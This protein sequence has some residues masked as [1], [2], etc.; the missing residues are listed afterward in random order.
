[1]TY[2]QP[3]TVDRYLFVQVL[4]TTAPFI[5]HR[6]IDTSE[7]EFTY[8]RSFKN[9][10]PEY[11]DNR[12]FA[13]DLQAEA[14]V[15]GALQTPHVPRFCEYGTA[16]DHEFLT[17]K[18]IWGKSLLQILRELKKHQKMLSDVYACHIANEVCRCLSHA[19]SL[20]TREFPEGIVHYN[21]SPRNIIISYSGRVHVVNFG[22]KGPMLTRENL[23]EFDFRNLSYL[24]PEQISRQ[25]LSHKSDL[26][27]VGALLYEMLTGA[28]PFLERTADKIVARIAKCSFL[29]ASQVNDIS[30]P[31]L[32]EFLASALTPY[33]SDRFAS[34]GLMSESLTSYLVRKHPDF[35]EIKLMLLMKALFNNEIV[36]DIKQIHWL[37]E[38]VEPR[39]RLLVKS[40]P[41]IMYDTISEERRNAGFDEDGLSMGSFR[42]T[43][44]IRPRDVS[45]AL[46]G[47][48]ANVDAPGTTRQ[49]SPAQQVPPARQASLARQAPPARQVELPDD[50]FGEEFV[51]VSYTMEEFA[52]TRFCAPPRKESFFDVEDTVLVGRSWVDKIPGEKERRALLDSGEFV[53]EFDEPPAAPAT[54]AAPTPAVSMTPAPAPLPEPVRRTRHLDLRSAMDIPPA[55]R[56][57]VERKLAQHPPKLMPTA[58]PPAPAPPA[59]APVVTAPT[60]P[61]A[62]P[63]SDPTRIRFSDGRKYDALAILNESDHRNQLIGRVLGEYTITGILGWGGMGTVYDGIQPTI[64]KE[65][66]IKVLNPQLCHDEK[67]T[68][69]FLAEAKAVNSIRNP[70]IIDIFAFGVLEGRFHYFVMEKLNG[71]PLSGYLQRHGTAPVGE[72]YEIMLQV[73]N[74]VQAAHEKGIIHRDLKPDNIFLENRALFR[75]YVKILDFGIAKFL[76]AKMN[77]GGSHIGAPI[78]TPEYMSPEHC[79]NDGV[80]AA[81]DIYSLGVI[82]FE[83]FTGT[84]PFRKNSYFETILAH[85]REA[86]P[87]PST[88]APMDQ[89]LE[90]IILW[91][92]TKDPK[93]R[94]ISVRELGEHLLP[95]LKKMSTT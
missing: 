10:N 93:K 25:G 88:L 46:S 35:D 64:G 61:A 91:T 8:F 72:T 60:S 84:Y 2:I 54:P 76:S 28:P 65:V 4:S 59:P 41:R 50:D 52:K 19:H 67:M 92:L 15:L 87:R 81:S 44:S 89:R 22:H 70:H 71:F 77:E 31:E 68:Q 21:L 38:R 24:S 82:L 79:L 34:A 36:D 29:P 9:L 51:S 58:A 7:P 49:A 3:F 18:Y 66:A 33:T 48:R 78:G 20:R 26:F 6:V 53:C 86:P 14:A 56:A 85:M 43:G 63:A 94:P 42:I 16:H 32:D 83:M 57:E 23:G 75:N 5:I 12:T 69:R 95:I 39:H 13:A 80:C 27:T 11:A 17:Y 1:M 73:L 90:D 55:L 74:A 30:P 40:I 62:P 47:G 45:A 37:A